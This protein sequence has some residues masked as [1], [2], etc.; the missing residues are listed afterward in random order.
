MMAVGLLVSGAQAR[1]SGSFMTDYY[2]APDV[3]A[4]VEHIKSLEQ[5]GMLR[6]GKA[7][8][9]VVGFLAGLFAENSK[10]IDKFLPVF[11][12]ETTRYVLAVALAYAGEKE[13]AVAYLSETAE[14]RKKVSYIEL[15]PENLKALPIT[16]ADDL[17]I[18]WGA[19]F[20]TG[21]ATYVQPIF[22]FIDQIAQSGQVSIEDILI[23]SAS[24]NQ[25][26]NLKE[27][28]RI[29]RQYGKKRLM[30]MAILASA[31][32]SV[33]SNASRHDFI[34]AAVL[35]RIAQA[36][37]SNT[38]QILH[39]ALFRANEKRMS[40]TTGPHNRYVA[41]MTQDMER[42][43]QDF[44]GEK[45]DAFGPYAQNEFTS[46]DK[47]VFAVMTFAGQETKGQFVFNIEQPSK[48]VVETPPYQVEGVGLILTVVDMASFIPSSRGVHTVRGRFLSS[49]GAQHELV[50]KFFVTR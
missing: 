15:Y 31:I 25:K 16:R 40:L 4:A 23:L 14:G 27:L 11:S 22:Y 33:G 43:K 44:A 8:P 38:S 9:P 50:K 36:P 35:N 48:A 20:A 46:T 24:V 26:G 21:D 5:E 18:L 19:T 30:K 2:H 47:L 6:G 42:I 13:R 49:D 28:N 10:S 34:H 3:D 32:W 37:S 45:Y 39:R 17:D 12:D 7:V 29:R 41:F 1:S